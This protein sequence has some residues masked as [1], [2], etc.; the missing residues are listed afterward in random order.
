MESFSCEGAGT[1]AQSHA[2]ALVEIMSKIVLV[3]R[4]TPRSDQTKKKNYSAST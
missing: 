3:L 2:V 4:S 1:E